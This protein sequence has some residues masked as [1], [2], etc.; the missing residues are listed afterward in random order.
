M[1]KESIDVN[2][3]NKGENSLRGSLHLD[4]NTTGLS[5]AIITDDKP[6]VM[7]GLGVENTLN[8]YTINSLF[9]N[10]KFEEIGFNSLLYFKEIRNY[11]IKARKDI[12]T[13]KVDAIHEV[14]VLKSRLSENI[15]AKGLDNNYSFKKS[16]SHQNDYW[17]HIDNILF[18]PLPKSVEK[19]IEE[20]LTE[21]KE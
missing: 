6:K 18:Q 20:N 4:S 19:F 17:K 12:E 11:S 21:I 16:S 9:N 15:D 13:Q 8:N 10:E 7:K 2:I 3:R 14:F 1:Q 5:L